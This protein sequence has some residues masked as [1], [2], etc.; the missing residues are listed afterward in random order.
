MNGVSEWS[1]DAARQSILNSASTIECIYN[2]IDVDLFKPTGQPSEIKKKYGVDP[3]RKLILGV[4]QLWMAKKGLDVFLKLADELADTADIILVG[5]CEDVPSRPNL[6]CIGFTANVNELIELYSAADA[7]VNASSA[8]TFGLVTVEAMACGTP[9]VAFD[10]SGSSEL[11]SAE[12]GILAKDGDYQS[13][14]DGVTEVLNNSKERYSTACRDYVCAN[15]EKNNQLLKY[16]DF[17]K[18]LSSK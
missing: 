3:E 6:K 2:F 12:C 8:E 15:F 5:K 16:I 10:N 17:Y 1:T 14:S 4:S 9:V 13:L 7:L 11:V 18:R